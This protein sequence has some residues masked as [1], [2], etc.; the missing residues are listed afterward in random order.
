MMLAKLASYMVIFNEKGVHIT[1]GATFDEL[2]VYFTIHSKKTTKST[3]STNGKQGISKIPT[4]SLSTF[5]GDTLNG[6]L[7]IENIELAFKSV[8]MVDFITNEAHCNNHP[9]CPSTFSSR[10]R[11]SLKLLTIL[12]FLADDQDAEENGAV[13][14]SALEEHLTTGDVTMARDFSN[15]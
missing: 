5:Q 8:T 1:P 2:T 9:T 15:W 10:L 7:Y 12:K 14:Y 11:G 6:D 3:V 4:F 13:V